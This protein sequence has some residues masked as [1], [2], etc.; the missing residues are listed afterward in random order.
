MNRFEVVYSWVAQCPNDFNFESNLEAWFG[1]N[2]SGTIDVI[3]NKI[4][5]DHNYFVYIVL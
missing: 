2:R 4:A 1:F 3:G 5:F